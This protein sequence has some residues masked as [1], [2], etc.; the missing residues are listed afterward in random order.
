MNYAV[1]FLALI[2]LFAAV[3]WVLDGRKFYTGPVVEADIGEGESVDAQD[4][5]R[6]IDERGNGEKTD[7]GIGTF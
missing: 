3:Y 1:A 6:G 4:N 2:F 7:K 5:V